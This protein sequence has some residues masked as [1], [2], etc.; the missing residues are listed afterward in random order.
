MPESWTIQH[1]SQANP[2]GENQDDVPALLQRV[3]DT[4]EELGNVEVQD[5]TFATEHTEWGDDWPNLTV[6]FHFS[7]AEDNEDADQAVDRT[8]RE[9]TDGK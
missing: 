6:Y 8:L 7:F 9:A 2:K 5:I 3:A 4:I 1:F